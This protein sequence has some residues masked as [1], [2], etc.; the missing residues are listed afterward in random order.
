[1]VSRVFGF[2]RL[3]LFCAPTTTSI[4]FRFCIILSI[5]LFAPLLLSLLSKLYC[6]IYI[7]V[8]NLSC[9]LLGYCYD[10]LF[11]AV[12]GLVTEIRTNFCFLWSVFVG[13]DKIVML[14]FNSAPSFLFGTSRFIILLFASI[15]II[16]GESYSIVSGCVGRGL[17]S[18]LFYWSG[19]GYNIKFLIEAGIDDIGLTYCLY[20]FAFLSNFITFEPFIEFSALSTKL[21]GLLRLFN[22]IFNGLSIG[23]N[24]FGLAWGVVIWIFVVGVARDMSLIFN[25]F[26]AGGLKDWRPAAVL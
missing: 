17:Y 13:D 24:Y 10:Y 11:V 1:M 16:F 3:T 15:D 12:I 19:S 18:I 4:F 23:L 25:I 26:I 6:N 21:I 5:W 14:G 20:Y 2:V 22:S 7:A 8:L 9:D